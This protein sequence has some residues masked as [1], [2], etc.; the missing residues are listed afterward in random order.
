VGALPAGPA[1]LAGWVRGVG[2]YP[3]THPTA[4]PRRW[5]VY[6][7]RRPE[8]YGAISTLDGSAKHAAIA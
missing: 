8:L 2:A 1:C 7:D 5:G 6:R 4:P 3:P